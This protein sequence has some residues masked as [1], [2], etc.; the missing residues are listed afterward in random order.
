MIAF[1]IRDTEGGTITLTAVP[2]PEAYGAG[3]AAAALLPF[4]A[5]M[6]RMIRRPRAA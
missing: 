2:E 3:A 4:G 6:I 1:A 5:G